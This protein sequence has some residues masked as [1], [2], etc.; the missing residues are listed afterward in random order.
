MAYNKTAH[1]GIWAELAGTELYNTTADPDE[2][3]N[4][5]GEPAFAGARARL[6]VQLHAGWRAAG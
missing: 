2:D 6:S 3:A 4:V 5:A 1:A